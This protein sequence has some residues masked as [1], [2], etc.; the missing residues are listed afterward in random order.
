MS[1][2]ASFNSGGQRLRYYES[3]TQETDF[4]I[5]P[6]TFTDDFLGADLA[7]PAAG[8]AESGVKWVKK[9]VGSG[10]PT[11]AKVA[12]T[13]GGVMACTLES[14]SQKQDA[15]IYMNDQ[16]E[17]SLEKKLIFEARVKPS[18][19]PTGVAELQVG[20]VGDWIDGIDNAT[21]SAFFTFDGSGEIFCEVDDN[22]TD[23]SAT[24]GVTLTATD[25]AILRIDFSDLTNILF[26]V[27]GNRVASSTTF[28]YAATGAN[29]TLQ[30]FAQAY[31]ASGTDVGT[32]LVDAIRI[33]QTR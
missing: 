12:S 5:A 14:T 13:I 32:L 1:T 11:V 19:L 26:Y 33:A 3:T 6:C 21:Y 10:P 7:V 4:I 16:R 27:N 29:A 8:S 24:S 28:V 15:M 2:K 20:L 18:V 23:Q 22:A 31:K 30:P 9:I 25:W 17:F